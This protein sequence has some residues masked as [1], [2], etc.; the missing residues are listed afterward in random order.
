M[1]IAIFVVIQIFNIADSQIILYSKVPLLNFFV[2][3]WGITPF[4]FKLY[5]Y[6]LNL[7]IAFYLA[8]LLTDVKI[9][10]MFNFLPSFIY[11]V[12][13]GMGLKTQLNIDV[14]IQL[15]FLG[16]ST[17]FTSL[18]LKEK[19]SVDYFFATG[20]VLGFLILLQLHYF[21]YLI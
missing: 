19:K 11:L 4:K 8:Y 18:L 15:L 20:F 2:S 17:H 9:S 14:F 16:L 7:I 21:V 1:I 13:I 5:F 10:N 3:E 12:H 6:I